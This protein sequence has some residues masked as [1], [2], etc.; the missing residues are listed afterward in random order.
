VNL[1]EQEAPTVLRREDIGCRPDEEGRRRLLRRYARYRRPDD[2]ERLVVSYRPL[3]RGLARRYATASPSTED[4]EQVAYEGLIKA[5]QRFDPHKG[6]AFTSFAVPTILGELRRYLRDTVWPAHVPRPLQER[7]REVRLAAA[8][9]T[10]RHGRSPTARDIA[11]ALHCDIEAVVDALEVT[12][13]LSVASL[14]APAADPESGRLS[15]AE[16]VGNDDPGYE[17]VECLATIEQALPALPSGQ[18]RA[19]RLHFGEDLTSREIA[20]RLGVSRS[21]AARELDAA[22]TTLRRLQAA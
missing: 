19:L 15:P 5:I 2:L 22:V 13:S 10:A 8:A 7:I 9:F 20:R 12:S 1:L 17:R 21:A 6:S 14:D 4:L 3:A 16:L 11:D 18:K